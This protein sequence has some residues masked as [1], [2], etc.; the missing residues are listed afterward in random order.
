MLLVSTRLST[1]EIQGTCQQPNNA[2]TA[3]QTTCIVS[4]YKMSDETAHRR[5]LSGTNYFV[6]S[7][8]EAGNGQESVFDDTI[9]RS[10]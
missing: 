10:A 4:A 5:P 8:T 6:S 3:T 9:D 7:H 2:Q 1:S